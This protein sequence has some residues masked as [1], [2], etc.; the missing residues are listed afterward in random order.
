I[1]TKIREAWDRGLT[2]LFGFSIDATAT[3]RPRQ[4][5]GK[6]LRE[7]TKFT[8]VASVDLI[9]EPGAGGPIVNL[10]EA[11]GPAR[12]RDMKLYETLTRIIEAQRPDLKAKLKP[13]A[14]MTDEAVEALLTEALTP[15]SSP[16]AAAAAAGTVTREELAAALRMVEAKSAMRATI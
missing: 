15:W 9:V 7:A 1:G 2:H 14:D 4:V 11:V 5:G 3:A 13:E 16:G 6:T 12:E 8:K 10:I